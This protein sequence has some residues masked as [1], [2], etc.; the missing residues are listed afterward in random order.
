MTKPTSTF[1]LSKTTKTMMSFIVD[2]NAR[3]QFKRMMI[4]AEISAKE[5]PKS[6][7]AD[8]ATKE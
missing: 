4:D 7:K 1:K 3:H 5:R 6:S 8:K 2:D